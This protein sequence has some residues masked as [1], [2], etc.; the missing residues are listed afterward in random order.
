MTP[1]AAAQ[2]AAQK[3]AERMGEENSGLKREAI[4]QEERL[5]QLRAK[6]LIESCER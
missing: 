1:P 6:I 2:T 4:E 3:A 5:K